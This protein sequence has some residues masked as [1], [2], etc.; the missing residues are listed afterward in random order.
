MRDPYLTFVFLLAAAGTLATLNPPK[1]HA[2]PYEVASPVMHDN[3]A[4]YLIHGKTTAATT[5]LTLDAALASGVA[6]IRET[7][8]G[9]HAIDNASDREIFIHLGDLIRGGSQDQVAAAS[10]VVPPK[11][12]GMPIA[13][14]CVERDRS[15]PANVADH[16]LFFGAGL[17]PSQTAKLAMLS[18]AP[19]SLK[20]DRLRRIA[21]WLT[22]ES[23][24]RALSGKLGQEV[25][26]P[27]SP[28][29]L[30]AALDNDEV[31]RGD[32]RYRDVF[33]NLAE[34]RDDGIGV[35]FAINGQL[36]G[37][38]LY[39]S[40]D[41]FRL[42][43][44][45]VLR[46]M[47][48]EALA[49]R[50]EGAA[51]PPPAIQVSAFLREVEAAHTSVGVYGEAKRADGTWLH[52]TYVAGGP[53]TSTELERV[54][55]QALGQDW[56][57]PEP[58]GEHSFARRYHEALLLQSLLQRI[59]DRPE[60]IAQITRAGLHHDP[61]QVVLAHGERVVPPLEIELDGISSLLFFLALLGI[62][63][64]VL[65]K[66]W[67]AKVRQ[68]PYLGPALPAPAIGIVAGAR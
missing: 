28:S 35:A 47:A 32:R 66:R 58:V 3:L 20:A 39:G 2:E 5:P 53:D 46:A 19:E 57:L 13:L 65:P 41:L 38:E 36:R 64:G 44:P 45:K 42:A 17:I 29:S 1:A 16:A 48:I 12:R 23:T 61:L 6:Q 33:Q 59:T 63:V 24:T 67:Y 27:S 68:R 55:L 34:N 22:A 9:K 4:V 40:A 26:S 31:Q 54:L 8:D 43:W 18:S 21:T 50:D 62:G 51:D 60:A 49:R 10:V 25:R 52:R 14:F 11:V 7:P 56:T 15:R 30:P 37:A